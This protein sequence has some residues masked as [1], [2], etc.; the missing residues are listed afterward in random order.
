VT[1]LKRIMFTCSRHQWPQIYLVTVEHHHRLQNL[2]VIK[3]EGPTRAEVQTQVGGDA[4]LG[5]MH[6]SLR[7]TVGKSLQS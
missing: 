2:V 4:L 5:S 6:A 3:A 7:A 1:S